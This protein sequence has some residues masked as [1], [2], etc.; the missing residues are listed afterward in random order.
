MSSLP[1]G[2]TR[3]G[4]SLI[5][6]TMDDSLI[7]TL[8]SVVPTRA[9][10]V[11]ASESDLPGYLLSDQAGVAIIDTAATSSPIQK[12]T[13]RLAAQF[14][15]L[16]IIV[17][18]D[19]RDQGALSQQITRGT[20]YRFLHKPASAQRVKLFVDAAWRRHEEGSSPETAARGRSAQ[21]SDPLFSR[22]TLVMGGI[23]I[24]AVIGAATYMDMRP[25][26][27]AG[28]A[29]ISTAAKQSVTSTNVSSA[30]PPR[31]QTPDESDP[32]IEPLLA[33]AEQAL[34][35]KRLDDAERI[36]NQASALEP[37]N[38][39]V[40]FL[41]SQI[42]RE[43]ERAAVTVARSAA[44]AGNI[45][46]ALGV[47][48]EAKRRAGPSTVVNEAR[49][50]L[51]QQ[52]NQ[53]VA[54]FL[55]LAD[56]RIRE[57]SLIV[58]AQDNARFYIESASAIAP[59]NPRVRAAESDLASRLLARGRSSLAAGNQDDGELWL[60]AAADAG[61]SPDDI[62]TIRRDIA[63]TRI[64][65]KADTMARL[66]QLF[67]QRLN[68][69]RLMES[70]DSARFYLTQLEQS[71]A[72][73]PSTRLARVSLSG[74]LLEEAR[75]ATNRGD[76]VAAQGFV[77]NAR[78]LGANSVNAAAVERAIAAARDDSGRSA[79]GTISAGRLERL[80]YVP[81]DYPMEAR[82]KGLSGNVEL[83]FT[84]RSDG[85]VSDVS[86]ENSTPPLVFDEAA[87]DAVRKWR[88]RP[89]ER[90]GLAVDQ[91]VKLNLRF[92]MD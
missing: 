82:Q 64:N 33:R 59:D 43:R 3:L 20:V 76:L 87:I 90:D 56:E 54:N 50:D 79:D 48:D 39:R 35:S 91:R 75:L 65:A 62:T 28:R 5:V 14:P 25:Q 85:K 16:V 92:A 40:V 30:P 72:S 22:N 24:V 11:L 38:V 55:A 34:V 32:R 37:E 67:N 2:S 70:S 26:E 31:L 44:A 53:R 36:V 12:L 58:P 49:Q 23:A 10:A 66:S 29:K 78:R 41:S 80:R 77:S 51:S 21:T 47:L 86:V 61:A 74:R 57:G 45:N 52:L 83:T 69:G 60:A 4:E 27:D 8:E 71:D 9:L 46:R 17:A 13:E 89:Y 7:V 19:S 15:D 68:Q 73:H 84:V 42:K 18:G 81:P 1:Q 88:Y 63:R 6:L